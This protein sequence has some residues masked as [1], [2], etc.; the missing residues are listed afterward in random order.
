MGTFEL[1][2]QVA[3]VVWRTSAHLTNT[4]VAKILDLVEHGEPGVAFEL[5]C[6][7]LYEHC[8]PVSEEIYRGLSHLGE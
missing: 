6:T 4:D 7:Q 1:G 5:L 2:E 3:Q 8:W